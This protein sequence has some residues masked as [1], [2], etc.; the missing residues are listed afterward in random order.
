MNTLDSV[1]PD[2]A[3]LGIA[4]ESLLIVG[5]SLLLAASAQLSVTLPFSVVPLSLQPHAVLL[6]AMTMGSRRAFAAVALYLAEGCMGMPVFAQGMSGLMHLLGPRGGYL[7]SYLPV[8]IV[9]GTLTEGTARGLVRSAGALIVG[10]AMIL[11]LGAAWL[12]LYVGVSAGWSMGFAP[13]IVTDLLKDVALLSMLPLS[14][15]A[16][17]SLGQ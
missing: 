7:M 2:S 3:G 6:L 11:G 16:S 12:S 8:A 14:T 1:K 5:A 9:V 10:N 15:K 13:F 4:T 17:R